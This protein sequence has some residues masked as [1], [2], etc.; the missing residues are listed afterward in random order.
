MRDDG[1]RN[2]CG[3]YHPEGYQAIDGLM[4]DTVCSETSISGMLVL[5][6]TTWAVRPCLKEYTNLLSRCKQT[7]VEREIYL[8]GCHE[9]Q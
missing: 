4:R 3:D 6:R 5:L 1:G 7:L 2:G 8:C 9:N